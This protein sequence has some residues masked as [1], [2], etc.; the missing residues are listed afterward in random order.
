M[1]IKYGPGAGARR[2]AGGR[3][4]RRRRPAGRPPLLR[5]RYTSFWVVFVFKQSTNRST[6]QLLRP[7][8]TSFCWVVGLLFDWL[9][10]DGNGVWVVVVVVV[11][12]AG[13]VGGGE[14]CPLLDGGGAVF[15]FSSSG[16]RQNLNPINQSPHACNNA[17]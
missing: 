13:V 1:G 4:R 12:D 14:V 11:D 15:E 16:P 17:V 2:P 6:S 5:P 3:R 7:R 9:V 8:Y 10:G